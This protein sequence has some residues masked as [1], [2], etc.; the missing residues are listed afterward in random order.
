M[1]T[2]SGIVKADASRGL[3]MRITNNMIHNRLIR[4]IQDSAARLAK[5]QDRMATNKNIGKPSEDP[6]GLSMLLNYQRDLHKLQQAIRNAENASTTLSH[7]DVVLQQV[8]DLL[9]YVRTNATAMATDTVDEN[10]RSTMA[11]EVDMIIDQIIQKANTNFGG[12]YIFSGYRVLEQPY[13]KVDGQIEYQG[14]QGKIQQRI[15]NDELLTINIPGSD[16]FGSSSDGLF[17]ILQDLK[18]ALETNDREGIQNFLS[19]A[20]EE[21]NN[22]SKA[23]G[24]V[25]ARMNRIDANINEMYEIEVKLSSYLSKVKDVDI[26]KESIDYMTS[27]NTYQATLEVASRSLQMPSL[28][29]YLS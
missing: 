17:M 21:I 7:T 23:L 24:E 25:G 28:L 26:A 9:T 14:D 18:Q 29:D 3:K 22:I 8:S 19:L 20:D 2:E 11:N 27:Q 13:Q 4:N 15:G 10:S 12:R 6:L 16:I 1:I 5:S